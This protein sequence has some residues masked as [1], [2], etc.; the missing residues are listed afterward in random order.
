MFSKFAF[1][2]I[3]QFAYVDIC[4]VVGSGLIVGGLY[5]VLWGKGRE[6][7]AS[8]RAR[9]SASASASARVPDEEMAAEESTSLA[10]LF[11]P[12]VQEH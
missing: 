6:M 4:S 12:K 9:A 10:V 1:G 8:A 11:S 5:L 2:I 7:G 3:K